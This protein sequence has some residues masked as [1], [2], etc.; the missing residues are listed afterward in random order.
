MTLL[1]DIEVERY[2]IDIRYRRNAVISFS[3]STIPLRAC[4]TQARR[5]R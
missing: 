2:D 4:G 5:R 1:F 3:S